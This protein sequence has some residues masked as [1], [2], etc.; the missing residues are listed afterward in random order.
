MLS[1]GPSL[2]GRERELTVVRDFLTG[3]NTGPRSLVLD[4]PAGSGKTRL[5]EAGLSTAR[6]QG[7]KILSSRPSN[8]DAALDFAG[9]GDVFAG[10]QLDRLDPLPMPQRRALEVA[11]LLREGQG[12]SDSRAVFTAVRTAFGVLARGS[13]LIVAIE[14]CSGS[15]ARAHRRSRLPPVDWTDSRSAFC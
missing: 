15:I 6:A 11:L 4:G 8:E 1:D 9:L 5:W 3:E 7:M 13:R 2:V 12:E 14:T 10:V